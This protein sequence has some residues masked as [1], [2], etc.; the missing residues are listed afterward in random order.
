MSNAAG[1]AR[2]AP[3]SM[4]C[5]PPPPGFGRGGAHRQLANWALNPIQAMHKEALYIA[6]FAMSAG[7]A[8]E[9]VDH[10]IDVIRQHGGNGTPMSEENLAKMRWYI[11]ELLVNINPP[12]LDMFGLSFDIKD[13]DF[14]R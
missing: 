12:W 6:E 9:M 11:A 2:Q 5:A 3:T 13:L 10:F 14:A 8:W 7:N 1:F 4:R